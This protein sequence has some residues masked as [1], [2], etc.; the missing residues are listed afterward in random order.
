MLK[1]FILKYQ[2]S[3]QSRWFLTQKCYPFDLTLSK[4][5][6]EILIIDNDLCCIINSSHSSQE[7]LRRRRHIAYLW[8]VCM[9]TQFVFLHQSLYSSSLL[10]STRAINILCSAL[11]FYFTSSYYILY[12]VLY[13]LKFKWVILCEIYL[14][15]FA[16][17]KC[18]MNE[19]YMFYLRFI[20]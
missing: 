20:R 3:K 14:S 11:T 10:R 15:I 2:N 19:F 17:K 18:E 4:S 6:S 8:V 9:R 16:T 12:L 5:D 13:E 1:F 7:N